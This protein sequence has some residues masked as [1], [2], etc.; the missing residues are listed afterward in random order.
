VV[1]VANKTDLQNFEVEH[2]EGRAFAT[3]FDLHFKIVSAKT[4]AGVK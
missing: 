3:K 1:I 4:G 2:E